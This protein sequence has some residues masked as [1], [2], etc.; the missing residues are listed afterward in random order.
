MAQIIPMILYKMLD[1]LTQKLITDMGS[2]PIIPE[3]IKIGRF[4]ENPV[5]S[6]IYISLHPGDP[7]DPSFRDGI[8][9]L[10]QMQNI[11]VDLDWAREIGGGELWWRR[12]SA[13]IGCYWIQDRLD[14]LTAM[15]NSFI[16]YGR[17]CTAIQQFDTSNLIDEFGE[18]PIMPFLYGS[19]FFE[20][21]GKNQFIWR[22]K[23]LW[24]VLTA[25]P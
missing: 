15:D 4:Q 22:G 20:G 8:I 2:D 10:E 16:M 19:T 13:V 5:K 1:H 18:Q 9:T 25:K 11:A 23:V 24:Q 21:G 3:T 17:L 6:V 7:E 14:E 12:F